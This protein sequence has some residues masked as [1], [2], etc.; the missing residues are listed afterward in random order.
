MSLKLIQE[1]N[2]H[3]IKV[4][5]TKHEHSINPFDVL[6]SI[7]GVVQDDLCYSCI[8]LLHDAI[9]YADNVME[10]LQLEFA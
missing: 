2:L 3:G 5:V 9:V 1:T 8:K 4:R 6:V 7:D 10:E